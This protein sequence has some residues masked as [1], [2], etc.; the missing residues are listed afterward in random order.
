[1]FAFVLYA[2]AVWFAAFRW[3]RHWLGWAI[4]V[5]GVFGV[6]LVGLLHTKISQWTG[7]QFYLE[8]LRV[9]L[10]PFGILL[11]IVGGFLT[12]LPRRH[13]LGCRSCGYDLSGH[14]EVSPTCPECG[15][16]H[17]LMRRY[18]RPPRRMCKRCGEDLKYHPGDSP[19]C[20]ECGLRD[21]LVR[22][23]A[24]QP[25]TP[26]RRDRS[27]AEAV[28]AAQPAPQRPVT[29]PAKV[30]TPAQNAAGVQVVTVSST[31]ISR[32]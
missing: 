30:R 3:R 8:A 25:P 15:A 23:D 31:P 26:P 24:A 12:V 27:G 21:A 28:P 19:T 5:V 13:V 14:E 9:L 29:K 10:V 18:R 22:T 7:G 17:A 32:G 11:L 2:L 6:Y 1:M 16:A 20:P 4:V